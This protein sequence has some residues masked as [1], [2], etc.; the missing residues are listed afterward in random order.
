MRSPITG[1]RWDR[2]VDRK[3]ISTTP[4]AIFHAFPSPSSVRN[5]LARV[6]APWSNRLPTHLPELVASQFERAVVR[7]V[8]QRR[9]DLVGENH[10]FAFQ[11]RRVDTPDLVDAIQQRLNTGLIRQLLELRFD[12]ARSGILFKQQNLSIRRGSCQLRDLL[13]E[14]CDDE[15]RSRIA[16]IDT[17]GKEPPRST[18]GGSGLAD[19]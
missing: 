2:T 5:S 12:C 6:H 17:R 9:I 14:R 8:V 4:R 1:S 10:V 19:I 18:R 16:G 13:L 7:M 3:P 11:R 15:L